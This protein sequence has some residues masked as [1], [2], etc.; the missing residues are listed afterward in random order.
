MR[1][2][3]CLALAC[4]SL[5]LTFAGSARASSFD[6]S[7]VTLTLSVRVPSAML[8]V[9]NRG[10]EPLRF[11]VSAF[12]WDQKANG[13]MVLNPTSDIVFFPALLTLNPNEKRNLRVGAQVRPGASEKTYRIFVQELPPAVKAGADE[14]TVK[15][16]TKMGIPIFL[17][18]AG[19]KPAPSVVGLA[20]QGSSV[21]F[22]VKNGGTAHFRS[23]KVRVTAKD[24]ANKVLHSQELEGWYVLAGGARAYAVELPKA[25]CQGLSSIQVELESDKG[26]AKAALSNARC[27]P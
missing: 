16:L 21:K 12:S 27:S 15:V 3:S 20:V 18:P 13:D 17:E 6:V 7:P 4:A 2:L 25:A 11:Q 8:V 24:A 22:E 1:R 9:T 26:A 19:A 23:L 5:L 14:G 10:S